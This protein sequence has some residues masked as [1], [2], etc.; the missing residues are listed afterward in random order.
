MQLS[1]VVIFLFLIPALILIH[2]FGN[3]FEIFLVD[4]ILRVFN[5]LGVYVYQ[6]FFIQ[7]FMSIYP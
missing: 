5:Y 1:I 3:V 2:F 6:L 7:Y 4:N